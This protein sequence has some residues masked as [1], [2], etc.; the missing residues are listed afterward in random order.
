CGRPQMAGWEKPSPARPRS[1]AGRAISVNP[2]E[3]VLLQDGLQ[4]GG[5]K[6]APD[7]RHVVGYPAVAHGVEQPEMLVRVNPGHTLSLPGGQFLILLFPALPR[8]RAG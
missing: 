7:S 8:R 6:I 2:I 4:V 3:A 5:Q 1:R